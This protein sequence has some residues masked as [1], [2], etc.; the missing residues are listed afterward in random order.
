MGLFDALGIDESTQPYLVGG[1]LGAGAAG[2]GAFAL[3]L[4]HQALRASQDFGM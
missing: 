4:M 3:L 1:A 2:L